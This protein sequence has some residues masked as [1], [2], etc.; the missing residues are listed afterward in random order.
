MTILHASVVAVRV[1]AIALLVYLLIQIPSAY[2]YYVLDA[3][4]FSYFPWIT[5]ISLALVCAIL[6]LLPSTIAGILVPKN[7]QKIELGEFNPNAIEQASITIIGLWLAIWA[8]P[9]LVNNIFA[10]LM[11]DPGSH[12][13]LAVA[14]SLV[15]TIV[16]FLVGIVLILRASG[17]HRLIDR[18][19]R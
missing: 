18:L 11:F 14:N 6:W 9:D 12:E 19:R 2:S 8:I 3:G 13:R 7:I 5:T 15:T 16:E 4:A 17:I 10:Y 1:I